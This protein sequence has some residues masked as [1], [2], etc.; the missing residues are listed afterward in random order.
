MTVATLLPGTLHELPDDIRHVL[1]QDPD[2][3]DKRNALTP[4]GRNEWICRVT[5]VKKAETREVH[6][7]RL[8]EEVGT[9]QKRPCCR[10][11]CPHHRESAKKWFR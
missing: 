4:L 9:G 1:Q 10:P 11:G 2:L 3:A 8:S 5:I 6:I 7:E